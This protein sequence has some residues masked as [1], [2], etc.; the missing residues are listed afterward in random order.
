MRFSIKSIYFQVL[1]SF[2]LIIFFTLAI[3]TIIEYHTYSS[4][5]PILFTEIRTK[6]IAQNLSSAYTRDNGWDNLDLEIQRISNLDSLNTLD[7]STQR[8]IVRDSDGKTIYNSFLNIIR[9]ENIVLVEGESQFIIDFKTSKAV[10]IVTVYISQDYL[11][12]H[13]HAYIIELLKSGIYKGL[14]TAGIAFILSLLFSRRIT[15]PVIRLTEAAQS[16]DVGG[17]SNKI[18]ITSSDELGRLSSAFNSMITSLNSQRKLRKKLLTDVS[19]QINTPLN[20]IRL[21]A[22]GLS[23]GLVSAEEASHF[24]IAEVD[25][26]RNIIYDLDWLAETDSG[27]Y[28]LN[29]VEYQLTRLID[30][31]VRRWV[32]KAEAQKLKLIITENSDKLPPVLIDVIRISTVIGN[33][34]DNAMKYSTEGGQINIGCSLDNYQ[35]IVSV[36]DDGPA[37]APEHRSHIFERFYRIKKSD[38][39]DIPGRGLGLSIVKQI[40]E[41][42]KGRIWLECG[43]EKGNCFFFSLPVKILIS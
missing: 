13:A 32:H 28:T 3:S 39:P 36:C 6:T 17:E 31:E 22:R 42:H 14:I 40:V 9:I 30:E 38:K 5:L 33:L 34:I 10:G 7:E 29:K 37:I 21:E 4:Q 23:D 27:V 18:S 20:A 43:E 8:I 2:I 35:L 41:L 26:L 1:I 12:K 15:R 16:I 11:L 24:I 19:H 25:S